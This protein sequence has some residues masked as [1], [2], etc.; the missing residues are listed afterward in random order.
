MKCTKDY[1]NSYFQQV[2]QS[3]VK[4]RSLLSS[5]L[6]LFYP[7]TCDG[8]GTDLTSSEEV[9]CLTCQEKLPRTGY[10]HYPANPVAKIFRGR[11]D[12]RHAMAA[13]Y[14]R[15][16]SLLQSLIYQFKYHNRRDI[17]LQLGR[18]TGYM[19]LQSKWLHEINCIIPVPLSKARE[20]H[21]GYNQA[22]LLA[23]GIATV[24]KKPV[25]SHV[26]TRKSYRSSQTNKNRILRWENVEEAFSL[27]HAHVIRNQHVLLVDDVITTG[28]TTEACC[29]V[30][31]REK[32]NVSICSLA[33]A[34]HT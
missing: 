25:I 20:R 24:I 1:F 28:A 7:H 2:N 6:H 17:A 14:Y 12:I 16:A 4:M 10:Q 32:V 33:Y 29:Q 19:L 3:I 21:R 18:Q 11:A 31:L 15:K 13:Y 26:L 5:L 9:L 8:C 30:L 34:N 23:E 27:Q 22:A